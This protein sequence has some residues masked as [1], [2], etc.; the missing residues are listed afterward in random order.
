[1][2]PRAEHGKGVLHAAVWD[3]TSKPQDPEQGVDYT[4]PAG[5]EA[6]TV[7]I[8]TVIFVLSALHPKEWEQAIHNMFTVSR[9]AVV[10]RAERMLIGQALKPGGLLLIRDYGRHDLAQLRIKKDRLL[11][12]DVP[13]L[14]IRGDGTRVY[15]FTKE[16]LEGMLSSAPRKM[17]GKMFAVDQLGE[18]RRLVRGLSPLGSEA[19]I[20]S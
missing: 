5:V 18:D 16:E 9:A 6:G 10:S 17:E 3:I 11:D 1:M 20:C 4:L 14:Y 7:D 15:F 13:N 2:Y 8:I 19:D 12:P